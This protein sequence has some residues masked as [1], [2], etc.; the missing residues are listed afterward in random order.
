MARKKFKCPKCDRSFSMAAHLAR[1][2]N[3]IHASGKGRKRKGRP[4]KKR[5]A[6]RLG[7]PPGRPAGSR[8]V[9]AKD[10]ALRLLDGMRAYHGKLVGQRAGLDSQIEGIEAAMG[11]MGGSAPR[12]AGVKRRRKATGPKRKRAGARKLGRPA[13]AKTGRRTSRGARPG[14][15][16]E[17]IVR[18]L[19]Q[20]SKPMSPKEIASAVKATAYK[21]KAKNLTKAVSNT[22]PKIK[23]V[24][25]VGRG[26]Y[27]A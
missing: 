17:R 23:A 24:K 8:R 22:L 27:R 5:K 11:A 4:A 15:L 10:G 13:A 12:K 19:R 25:K 1:H 21:S 20:R 18:V 2:A 6:A 16:R 7:R 14:P 3:T 26:K 9:A